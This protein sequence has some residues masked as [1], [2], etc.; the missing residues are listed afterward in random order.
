MRTLSCLTFL[1][2]VNVLFSADP[3]TERHYLSGHGP[4]DAVAWDF[5]VTAGRRAGEKATIPVPSNWEQHG[6]GGYDYGEGSPQKS[7]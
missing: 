3:V 6:F 7:G 4:E 5:T 1:L 2:A